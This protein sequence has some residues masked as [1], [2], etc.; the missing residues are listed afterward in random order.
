MRTKEDVA[1][2]LPHFS[3]ELPPAAVAFIDEDAFKKSR[4]IFVEGSRRT[5]RGRV[6]TCYCTY[7]RSTFEAQGYLHGKAGECP[8]CNHS[9]RIVAAGRNRKY[10]INEAYVVWYEKS[11]IDPQAITARGIICARDYRGDF[12]HVKTQTATVALYVFKVGKAVMF[13]RWGYY[14]WGK[15]HPIGMLV[16]DYEQ[17]ASIHPACREQT[18]AFYTTSYGRVYEYSHD[19]IRKAVKNT[20]FQ[21]S[22]WNQ[23]D[24]EDN[25]DYTKYFGLFCAA[26]CV[27]YLIKMGLGL[28][29]IEKLQKHYTYGTVNWKGKSVTSVLRLDKQHIKAI[30]SAEVVVDFVFLK[31]YH[32]L[33]HLGE[34]FDPQEASLI[35]HK[36]NHWYDANK[37][38]FDGLLDMAER[39]KTSVRSTVIYIEKQMRA[40][41][42]RHSF[43]NQVEVLRTWRDYLKDC[44]TLGLDLNDESTK[45]PRNLYAAHQ[46]TISQINIAK[47]QHLDGKIAEQAKKIEKYKFSYGGLI[48]IPAGSSLELI[49]EGKTLNHCVGTYAERVA[50]GRTAI[51]F[52]RK[53]DQPN[54]PFYTMEVSSGSIFQ[55]RGLKNCNPTPVVQ[56]FVE[57]FQERKLAKVPKK[58]QQRLQVAAME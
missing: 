42:E 56:D 10:M 55:V 49:E 53:A 37:D 36:Y 29:V 57:A 48:A 9:Y 4:Y 1:I 24:V 35:A 31:I 23:L 21:Y 6:Q 50:D 38:G 8:T 54:K 19:S 7:C 52:I 43:D 45:M 33:L 15:Y 46:N 3:V 11:L 18:R 2:Y 44:V 39:M 32:K 25:D 13:K 20:P 47:N 41:D 16:G 40:R 27:E 22:C 58:K 14:S 26:P 17:T 51:L 5:S 12:H 30:M 34:K 28:L